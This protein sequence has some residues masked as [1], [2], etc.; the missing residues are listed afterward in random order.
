MLFVEKKDGTQQMCVDY[1]SLNEVTIK[2][3][4]LIPRI[5][6]LFDQI[7]G[8]SVFLKIDLI[9]GYHQLKIR[10]S[11]IS[12]TAFRTRYRLY[13]YTVMSFGLTNVPAYFMYLMNK[14]FME[15]L[16]KFVVVF[17]DDILIFS[18]MEEEYEKHLRMVLEKLRSNQLYAKFSKCEFWLTEVAFL[19][20]V[21]STGGVSV[22]LSKE[23]VKLGATDECFRDL[24]VPWIG[25][26]LLSV[27]KGFLQNSQTNDKVT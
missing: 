5:E 11:D 4:Y 9:L 15:Y 1:R 16:D 22:D 18:K 6:D 23:R 26:L 14:V 10:E 24:E 7:K 17:I 13:E 12:K 8:A 20:H 19:G 2:N 25:R 27:H 21:I 3:K